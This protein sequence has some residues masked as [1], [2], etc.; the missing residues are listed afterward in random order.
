MFN[1]NLIFDKIDYITKISLISKLANCLIILIKLLSLHEIFPSVQL[2]REKVRLA[3]K[4]LM[5]LE[6]FVRVITSDDLCVTH[7]VF[8]RY[9]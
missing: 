5:I 2:W 7:K 1:Y 4:C 9:S 8:T 3:P 6:W